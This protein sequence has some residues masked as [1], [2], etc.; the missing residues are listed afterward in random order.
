MALHLAFYLASWG[1]YRG[2]SYLLQRD[3]KAHKTAVG[4]ILNSQYKLLWNYSPSEETKEAA[5][6]LLFDANNGIYHKIK[7]SYKNFDSNEDLPSETLVTKILLGTFGCVTAFDSY[8]KEGIS[9]FNQS[10]NNRQNYG[11]T[12]KIEQNEGTNFKNLVSFYLARENEFK[13]ESDFIY[14]PMKLVDMYFWQIGYEMDIASVL[15]GANN[16]EKKRK[17]LRKAERSR[18]CDYNCDFS[19]AKNQIEA[20]NDF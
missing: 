19:T 2:S 17:A 12:Q 9:R 13:L 11:L 1:M 20:K 15:G 14:P 3:Y 5:A 6:R 18:L 7:Y 8:F 10:T 16:D 4:H